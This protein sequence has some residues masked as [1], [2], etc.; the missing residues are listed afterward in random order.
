LE[1]QHQ[2]FGA[3]FLPKLVKTCIPSLSLVFQQP[4]SFCIKSEVIPKGSKKGSGWV[5]LVQYV[6]G[7]CKK[8]RQRTHQPARVVYFGPNFANAFQKEK[9][10]KESKRKLRRQ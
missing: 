9:R 10:S 1:K 2:G 4:G 6:R 8:H 7:L 5:V 3:Q